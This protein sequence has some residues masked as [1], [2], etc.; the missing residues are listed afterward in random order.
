VRD[1]SPERGAR[2]GALRASLQRLPFHAAAKLVLGLRGLPVRG[3]VRAPL[4]GLTEDER[5]EVER[6]VAEW[7]A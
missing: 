6:I 1:P 7:L 2:V 5:T 4:R 3:A